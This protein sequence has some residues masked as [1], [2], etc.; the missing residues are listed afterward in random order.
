MAMAIFNVLLIAPVV[1][2]LNITYLSEMMMSFGIKISTLESQI[3][4]IF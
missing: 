1:I 4:I 2:L 3:S